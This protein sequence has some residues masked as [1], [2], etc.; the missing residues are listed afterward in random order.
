M[1]AIIVFLDPL[2][3]ELQAVV[4][5]EFTYCELN[6]SLVQECQILFNCSSLQSC[7]LIYNQDK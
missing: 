7:L 4:S 6:Y 2:E 1:K 5:H 3:L